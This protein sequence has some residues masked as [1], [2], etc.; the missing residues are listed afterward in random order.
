MNLIPLTP[1]VGPN[2]WCT[3]GAQGTLDPRLQIDEAALF[4][5]EGWLQAFDKVRADLCVV[6]DD[7]WD[8]PRVIPPGPLHSAAFGSCELSVERFPSFTGAPM[9]RLRTLSE[10][11]KGLGWRGVGLWLAAQAAGETDE[12]RLDLPALERYWRERAGW[13]REAGIQYWKV[14]WGRHAHSLEFRRML[15]RVAREEAPGLVVEHAFT[16][17][18]F[19]DAGS[20]AGRF[21][22]FTK[23]SYWEAPYCHGALDTLAVSDVL[24]TYDVSSELAVATTLDRVAE[25]L[26]GGRPEAGVR[27]LLNVEDELYLGAALG[28]C[29]GAMRHRVWRTSHPDTGGKNIPPD[30]GRVAERLDEVTRAVRWQRL[31]PPFGVAEATVVV[32]GHVLGDAYPY[33][34]ELAWSGVSNAT[35]EQRAPAMVARGMPLPE[36]W[37][38]GAPPFVVASRH[39]VTGAVAVATLPRTLNGQVLQLPR[40]D[41]A[42]EVPAETGAVGVFGRY[43]SLTLRLPAPLGARRV[44]A[45]DLAGDTA[46]DITARV[47]AGDR[48]LARTHYVTVPG[49]VIDEIGLADATPGDHSFPGLV[50]ALRDQ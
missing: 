38:D 48:P 26:K 5:A 7:G 21:R 40:V 49:T 27:G 32:D 41:V 47:Q 16:M 50:L 39:P 9:A 3:W 37:G 35:V 46:C 1:G 33:A 34:E 23:F 13:C 18:P 14:D 36:V 42:I 29:L 15:T 19:N 30:R 20:P 43:R 17:G 31:A 2:Y 11:I 12:R 44:W 22:D 8:V 25:L 6:L 4:G 45:Q 10:R 24:R 28:C